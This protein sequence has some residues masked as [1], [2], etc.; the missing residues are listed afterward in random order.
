VP[1]ASYTT[2]ESLKNYDGSGRHVKKHGGRL[3]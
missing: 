2:K 3:R 1:T